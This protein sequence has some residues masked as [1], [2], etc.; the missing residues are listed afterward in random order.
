MFKEVFVDDFDNVF[1]FMGIRVENSDIN[2]ISSLMV[3]SSDGFFL[4][5]GIEVS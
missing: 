5:E 2:P 1:L 3:F 4:D